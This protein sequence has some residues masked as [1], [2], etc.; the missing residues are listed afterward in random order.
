MKIEEFD[1]TEFGKGL[2][3]LYKGQA[4]LIKS[5]DFEER[6]V[7]LLLEDNEEGDDYELSW[8]RCEN[9]ELI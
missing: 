6:L 2:K 3:G 5:I 1:N 4:Y 8:V 9:I 7:G